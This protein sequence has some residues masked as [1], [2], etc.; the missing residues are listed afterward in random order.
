[1]AIRNMRDYLILTNNPLVPACM[2]G[3]GDFTIRLYPDRSY[4]DILVLARDMV[5]EGHTLYTHPLAGSVKPNETPYKSLI[6]S[7]AVHGFDMD[8]STLIANAIGVVDKFPEVH[9]DFP[10]QVLKDFQLI[11]YSLLAGAI[12][13][14]AVAGLSN[15]K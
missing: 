14:D 12:D 3:H 13:F 1:M 7:K 6:V 8:Q 5:Y 9:K 2:E 10:E 15:K 4:R 11:D